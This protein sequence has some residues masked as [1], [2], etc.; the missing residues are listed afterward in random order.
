MSR[1]ISIR[2]IGRLEL[3]AGMGVAEQALA[4]LPVLVPGQLVDELP[5]AGDLVLGQPGADEVGQ[6]LVVVSARSWTMAFS[7]SPSRSSGIPKTAQSTTA[8]CSKSTSS[9]SR[10]AMLTPPHNTMSETRSVMV[11]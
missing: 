8:G 10:G 11:R 6:L 7:R 9:I 1:S 4:H 3:P 5:L 2:I